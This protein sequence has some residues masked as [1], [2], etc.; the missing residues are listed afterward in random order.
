MAMTTQNARI[1]SQFDA[2]AALMTDC[3]PIVA[4]RVPDGKVPSWCLERGWNAFLAK[5][6]NDD[7]AAAESDPLSY[8]AR[9]ASTPDSLR[10]LAKRVSDATTVADLGARALAQP[11]AMTSVS[12]R[13][14]IQVTAL[15]HSLAPVAR[16]S[17]RVVD[18]GSGMGHLTRAA[19]LGWDT[20]ATGLERQPALVLE[21]R[22]LAKGANAS[23]RVCDVFHEDLALRCSDLVLSLH[24][25][26]EVAD[27]AL[28]ASVQVGARIALVSCCLQKIQGSTREALSSQGRKS[29]LRFG[30]D[31]LG[32]SNLFSREKGV[33][34]PLGDT[35][36]AL[37][38]RYAL[39]LLL[40]S[41]GYSVEPGDEM[42][43]LNRRRPRRGLEAVATDALAARGATGPTRVE[44]EEFESRSH[45]EFGMA[46]RLALPR[47]MLA[48][49]IECAIVFDRAVLLVEHGYLATVT[50]AF[51][52]EVSPR[53]LLVVGEPT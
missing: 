11:L 35:M 41:R 40:R 13:K 30:R 8:F 16:R 32:L 22:A 33:E 7:L 38:T 25:C 49:A 21:A 23:F 53:N 9:C 20:H 2:L 48:R 14:R 10:E 28:Q 12:D 27:I 4:E 17:A 37:R 29:G 15:V 39:R 50:T 52:P 43:G 45:A 19:S 18:V 3:R 5:L 47:N 42:R 1:M 46:R 24:A 6:S 51:T 34:V 31:V 36:A 44:L 26:G